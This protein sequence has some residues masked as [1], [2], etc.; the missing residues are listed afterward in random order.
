MTIIGRPSNPSKD[1]DDGEADELEA[2]SQKKMKPYLVGVVFAVLVVPGTVM[3]YYGI[4]GNQTCSED[5]QA[6][7]TLCE[8]KFGQV[9]VT[10]QSQNHGEKE[11][12]ESCEQT[13]ES[14]VAAANSR[15]TAGLLLFSG[16]SMIVCI[17]YV[18]PLVMG[19]VD[20]PLTE[21][22]EMRSCYIEPARTEHRIREEEKKRYRYF[23]Q[24]TLK[25]PK[26]ID[27]T[28]FQCSYVSSVDTK[29]LT[30]KKGGMVPAVC[31]RC[32]TV[33]AGLI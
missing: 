14:C 28:C 31:P 12:G 23:W 16:M 15:M 33:I 9:E 27:H 18:I 24:D 3:C 20:E 26:T 2:P 1:E 17:F 22:G 11:C 8:E 13:L 25:P 6:C 30:V 21:F 4:T 10:F 7:S 32:H 29:W 19:E 5:E